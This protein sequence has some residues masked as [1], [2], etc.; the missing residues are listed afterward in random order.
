MVQASKIITWSSEPL[1]VDIQNKHIQSNRFLSSDL[2][3]VSKICN[4]NNDIVYCSVES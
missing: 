3:Q 4:Y 2:K 1:A